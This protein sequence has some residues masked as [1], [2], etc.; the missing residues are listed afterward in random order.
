MRNP[1]IEMVVIVCLEGCHGSGKSTLC[2][3]FQQAGY[4]VLDE[5][6][7]SMESFCLHPQTLTME[8]LWV[9][10]WVER[11]LR[12][13]HE[14]V[15]A[16]GRVRHAVF[17]ADRSPFSA[18]LYAQRNGHL[19]EPLV[20]AALAELAE[21][22]DIHVLTV[23]IRVEPDVLWDRI[24]ARLCR[25]PHRAKFNEDSRAWM[26]QALAFYNDAN[27]PWDFT[28][29]NNAGEVSHVM[30]RVLG[31]LRCNSPLWSECALPAAEELASSV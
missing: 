28:V 24:Q 13:H 17:I 2:R 9:A 23:H 26:E 20:R 8:T 12:M 22:A 19:L 5:A 25:E 27:R 14:Q 1:N 30:A 7:L 31:E 11:L 15:A 18:V 6:F 21:K 16:D 4:A 29:S 3:E 10:H